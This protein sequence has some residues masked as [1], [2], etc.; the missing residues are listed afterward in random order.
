M[1]KSL[2]LPRQKNA[3]FIT[4]PPFHYRRVYWSKPS[5]WP[6]NGS[7]RQLNDLKENKKIIV[8]AIAFYKGE[9]DHKKRDNKPGVNIRCD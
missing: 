2:T 5:S 9:I 4:F 6:Q 1:R 8:K 7:F 3:L